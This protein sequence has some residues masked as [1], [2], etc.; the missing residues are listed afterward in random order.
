[1]DQEKCN[2]NFDVLPGSFH[3]MEVCELV[4]MFLLHAIEKEKKIFE[5]N[6]FGIYRDESLAI[7]KCKSGP[8]IKW[9]YKKKLIKVF[10]KFDL[11]TTTESCFVRNAFLDVALDL[12]NDSYATFRK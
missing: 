11:K 12:T 10:S 1:M 9:I 5:R 3:S 8:Y 7:V 6:K 2:Y 4:G